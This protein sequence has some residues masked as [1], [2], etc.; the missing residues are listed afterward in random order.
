MYPVTQGRV[1]F[2]DDERAEDYVRPFLRLARNLVGCGLLGNRRFLGSGYPLQSLVC[3]SF[4]LFTVTEGDASVHLAPYAQNKTAPEPSEIGPSTSNRP[5]DL[6]NA[7]KEIRAFFPFHVGSKWTYAVR[8]EIAAGSRTERV[9]GRYSDTVVA[10]DDTFGPSVQLVAI[11]R[12]GDA[13]KYAFCDEGTL[14]GKPQMWWY[15]VDRYRIFSRCTQKGA[16]EFASSLS[17][18]SSAESVDGLE[19]VLPFKVGA[20]W[21]CRPSLWEAR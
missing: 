5:P 15:V 13:P 17:A 14:H 1:T 3:L 11:K 6:P 16:T 2:R 9:R 21:G 20:S 10:V 4:L 19:Y 8:S 18:S 12:E 7:W